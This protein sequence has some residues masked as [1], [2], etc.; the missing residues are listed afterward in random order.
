MSIQVLLKDF[1]HREIALST[2]NQIL[3]FRRTYKAAGEF[4]LSRSSS[5][6]SVYNTGRQDGPSRCLV[7]F[8]SKSSVDL[9]DFRNVG[10]AQGTLGLVTLN[11]DV[12]LCTISH[13][14]HVA[15][16][17][18]GETVQKINLVEFF[19]LN[20]REY[21]HFHG[22]GHNPY[23][24]QVFQSDDV[25][26]GGGFDQGDSTA[27]HPFTALRKLLSNGFFY[28]SVDFNLTSRIQDRA[29]S[30]EEGDF[31]IGSLDE[32][33]LWNSYMIEPLLT[34]RA[35]LTDFE[36]EALDRSRLLTSVIRGFVKTLTIPPSS[37]PLK[38][39]ASNLPSSLTVISRLSS[40]RA[41]T[42]F[43]SR[44]IDD[45]GNVAN[46]VETETIFWHPTGVCFSY[47]QIRGSVPVFW[48]SSSSLI[49][50]QQKIQITRSVEATQPAFDKHFEGLNTTYGPIH[51]VNLLSETK[52]GEYELS[53]RYQYHISK[54]SLMRNGEKNVASS[55]RMLRSTEYDFH[56]ETR[57]GNGYEGARMIRR[58]LDESAEGFAY[59]LSEEVVDETSTVNKGQP[60]LR[61]T[62]VVLQQEGMFR[63]NCL[64]CLD[65]TNLVQGMISQMAMESFLNHRSERASPDFWT[66]HSSLW[67]D[68]GDTLSKIY[69]GT[70]ALKSSFTRHGKMSLAGAIADVR[71]SATRL[72][73]N[74]FADTARQNTIDLLLGRLMGQTP[75][76]LYDPI[77]D[78][79][80]GELGRR[81]SEYSSEKF[82]NVWA[83]TF[84]LN[85]RTNGISEDLSPWLCAHSKNSAK[86]PEV[87]AVGFQEIVELSPQQIM[88]T[89]PARRHAW[90]EAVKRTLNSY[91]ASLRTDSYV[92]LRSGQ[93]VGAALMVFVKASVLPEIKNVEG[94]IKKTGLSGIAGNK[95]AVAIRFDYGSTSLCFVTAH[96]AAGFANYEERNRDYKTITQGLHFLKNRTIDSHSTVI[97]LGDFNYRIGL[98][99]DRCRALVRAN[100]LSTLYENDQLNLQMVAGLAFPF[101]SESRITFPPTYKYDLRSDEYDT[102]EKSRIPAWT[103]R[104]LRKGTNLKQIDYNAA[105][106]RFSD[107][108]PVYAS[109][110]C[111]ITTVNEAIKS[112]LSTEIYAKRRT[113]LNFDSNGAI[114][115]AQQSE[116]EAEVTGYK[117]IAPGELPP[118]SSNR[119]KWWLDNDMPA[120][121][122]VQP[123]RAGLVPNPQR[124]DNPWRQTNESDWVEMQSRSPTEG[125]PGK[126]EKP[127]VP[128]P[129]RGTPARKMIV[130]EWD[131]PHSDSDRS[132]G[133]NRPS[134][135]PP[136]A[137]NDLLDGPASEPI[138]Q[139]PLRPSNTPR[140]LSSASIGGSGTSNVLKK[141]PP[142]KPKKPSSLARSHSSTDIAPSPPKPQ[143]LP[144][145]ITQPKP[146]THR[147]P[148]P[149][150]SLPSAKPSPLP[151][152]PT[153]SRQNSNFS[154]PAQ[155]EEESPPLP[156]RRNTEESSVLAPTKKKAPPQPVQPRGQ[157]QRNRMQ[158]G[159]GGGGGGGG[160]R[161]EQQEGERPSLPPRR[162]TG[163]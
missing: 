38:Q 69:A 147:R 72:Y 121:S 62:I 63:T 127:E 60:G 52:P 111:I 118:A 87:I 159:G 30:G 71:K 36:R 94:S 68:N 162:G 122:Q 35:R 54:C 131:G 112:R 40:R 107:H 22:Q 46:F 103:D 53:E 7:E 139:T 123:P 88:S 97:W 58:Y 23:P 104:I 28:Y 114:S 78:Y 102:S 10:K 49:P 29:G 8:S 27:E 50:G 80:I 149:P 37:A 26:Y 96:L 76:H 106:L 82:I 105:P 110:E 153:P 74:N 5:D 39:L 11:H 64:D 160:V 136:M 138:S 143:T 151:P 91:A 95:G 79:V 108:R 83:G 6:V 100:D 12:F 14:S 137:A 24:N 66:R 148:L 120:R 161:G 4:G 13:S 101:Y 16:V 145:T 1:P 132:K 34:F 98:S 65:R 115:S 17:R 126:L 135:K 31:D 113:E 130:P 163:N 48:E 86:S 84:N 142:P 129:R 92:L 67:A 152:P 73:V 70:G 85:G 2:D 156:S 133:S 157:G 77:N 45:D 124:P 61:R 15:T 19:C 125:T 25:D 21:D 20:S 89:D 158:S 154:N 59:F 117:S 3:V 109:F 99:D 81:A 32:G 47:V 90:E 43:N 42:R 146:I 55:H 144:Q 141:A 128:P 75:V 56:A 57:G 93:L 155:T 41:G 116:D 33:L 9:S 51:I 150:P 44:G 119:R 134:P 140:T 18:P